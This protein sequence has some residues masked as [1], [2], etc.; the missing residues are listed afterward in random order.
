MEL[1]SVS[2]EE[3]DA[4]LAAGAHGFCVMGSDGDTK[5]IWDPTDATEVDIAERSFNELV[6]KGYWAFRVDDEGNKTEKMDRFDA[7]AGRVILTKAPVG[8]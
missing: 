3:F 7:K 6:G 4:G 5:Y 2:P 1:N 8:G